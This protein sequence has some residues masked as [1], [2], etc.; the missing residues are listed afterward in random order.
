MK[1]KIAAGTLAVLILVIF[2]G[3]RVKVDHNVVVPEIGQDVG[4]YV[5]DSESR[6]TDIKPGAEKLIVWNNPARKD[7]TPV[8]V[9]YLH[10]FS[11]CRQEVAPLCDI[12]A[13]R[14]GANLFYARLRGH[15]RTADA[16]KGVT[17]NDWL[18]DTAEAVEIGRRIGGK[19]VIISTSTGGTLTAWYGV[20]RETKDVLAAVMISPNF[21][22]SRPEARIMTWPWGKQLARM[23]LGEYRSWKPQSDRHALYWNYRQPSE[24]TVTMMGLVDMVKGLDFSR[25]R[26]PLMMIVSPRDRVIN[27][28]LAKE[29]FAQ[30]SSAPKRLLEVTDSV[31]QS[32]HVL[33][34]DILSP[35]TTERLAGEI[36]GFLRPLAER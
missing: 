25:F 2:L 22:P 34:G 27:P 17:V 16:M 32:Q 24:I 33:A 20:T 31:D 35:N 21:W 28:V 26:L 7:R 12:V 6:F 13:K 5:L 30:A 19:V 4:K 11:A 29:R 18:T 9:I 10:G 8:S 3:P 23:I 14:L 1:K 15:G 36:V